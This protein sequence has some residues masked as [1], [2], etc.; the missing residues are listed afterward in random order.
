MTVY[1]NGNFV[2]KSEVSISPDDRGFLFGDGV[3][4]VIRSE[5]GRLF[6]PDAHVRRLEQSLRKIRLSGVD[7]EA[8]V[9]SVHSLLHHNDLQDR[10]AK[11]YLQVTRGVAPRQHAFPDVPT[12]PTVYATASPH[13]PPVDKWENGV[14]VILRPDRRWSRCDIKSTA[15]LPNVLANQEAQENDAYETVLVREGFITEGS[16]TSVLGVFDDTVVTHPITNRIL[17]SITRKVTLDLCRNLG[18]PVRETPILEEDLSDADELI[19]AG[20][21]TGVMP[22]IQVDDSLVADGTPGPIT[23]DLQEA[24]HALELA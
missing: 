19:L 16:H 13:D 21:T 1:F 24:F 6:Q 8:L 23:R 18:I 15:L 2:D 9:D 20:T 12:D 5:D 14:R 4:E 10:P 3:Y 22:I 11:I 17:P 7:A